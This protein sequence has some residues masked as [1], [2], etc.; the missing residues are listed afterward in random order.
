MHHF[1]MLLS[2]TIVN[3]SYFAEMVY[4]LLFPAA[5]VHGAGESFILAN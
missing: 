2:S 1:E 4:S 5:K 3:I